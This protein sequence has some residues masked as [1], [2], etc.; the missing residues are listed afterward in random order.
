[1]RTGS[2]GRYYS[3]Y[4]GGE[5]ILEKDTTGT[6]YLNNPEKPTDLGKKIIA[7]RIEAAKAR[8]KE[9]DEFLKLLLD[10]NLCKIVEF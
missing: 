9:R 8:V 5:Q 6:Y 10:N 7:Q 4:M 3:V 1:M 2:E